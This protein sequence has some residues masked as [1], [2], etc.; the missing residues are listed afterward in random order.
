MSQ[1][2][3]TR[4]IKRLSI[5]V[6]SILVVLAALPL[7]VKFGAIYGL[8]K[9]GATEVVIDDVDLNLF[10]GVLA[11]KGLQVGGGENP[12]LQLSYLQI[13]V[14]YLPLFEKRFLLEA[15]Q[16]E[17]VRLNIREQQDR[18][19][20]VV[21]IPISNPEEDDMPSADGATPWGVG[22]RKVVLRDVELN[23]DVKNVV[24]NV[25]VTKFDVSELYSW[26]P[27]DVSA[28]L[29]EGEINGAPL[30]ISGNVQPFAEIPEYKSH[31][32]IDALSLSPL[33]PFLNGY[34][35]SYDVSVSLDTDL[36][37]LMTKDGSVE[38]S[39]EGT[40]DVEIGSIVRKD[41]ELKDS[42]IGW[43]GEVRLELPVDADLLVKT[44]GKL[45]SRALNSEFPGFQMGIKHQGVTWQGAVSID[46]KDVKDVENSIQATGALALLE[47]VVI[48]NKELIN[49]VALQRFSVDEV[50]V[51]GLNDIGLGRINLQKLAVL[52]SER[53]SSKSPPIEP[54]SFR[55]SSV[56]SL[57]DIAI[58][59]VQLKQKNDIAIDS[60]V[61]NGLA[62]NITVLESGEL[63][64]ISAYV[65]ALTSR[66]DSGSEKIE[67][68][69]KGASSEVQ[70][71]EQESKP[72]DLE[73]RV[74]DSETTEKEPAFQFALKE[75][76][77]DG[78]NN[79]QFSDHSVTPHYS[80]KFHID[81]VIIGPLD[82]KQV[83]EL[84][85]VDVA[86]RRGEFST[87]VLNGA[88][89]PLQENVRG[90]LEFVVKGAELTNVSSYV[91]KATG[92]A[93]GSGQFNL[94][95][96]VTL[97]NG[98]MQ[99]SNEVLLKQLVLTPVND[100]LVASV[101]KQFSM[102]IGISLGL[103]KDS[104]GNIELSVPLEGDL[105]DPSV[106]IEYVVRLAL[107]QAIKKGSLSYLKYAIQPYGAIL[108]VGEAVG[109]MVMEVKVAPFRFVA[110]S[111]DIVDEDLQ[112]VPKLAVLL[113]SL[114]D[115]SFT[116][117]P[118]VTVEDDPAQKAE[119]EMNDDL[120]ALAVS[121]L[122]KIK[123]QLV[124]DHEIAP[125][126]ILFCRA[127]VGEGTP[128]V[129]LEF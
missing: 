114:P 128:R 36:R 77:F 99:V 83:S 2:E 67:D 81:K 23:V 52:S 4:T 10:A 94:D 129:E 58:E 32:K 127:K 102:P 80:E 103:L 64:I 91:E 122:A 45:I 28:L 117:C 50:S 53:S 34:I 70:K 74:V 3:R 101:S 40:F 29:L 123:T 60:I 107:V 21:P 14:A 87:V 42:H 11:I 33:A 78:E 35:E 15:V 38:L 116:M 118:I 57:S 18:L 61:L 88:L 105:N 41:V 43:E 25:Q 71:N 30:S 111:S 47:L 65:E 124:S 108:L 54:P 13:E 26:A 76:R 95:T 97:A 39:Q 121:R 119:M 46:V 98:Q 19:Y 66:L 113:K 6:I 109:D 8:K 110:G 51:A 72:L 79:I 17:K 73:A 112:Y 68:V 120:K 115:K 93:I 37:I 1:P 100:E 55:S 56:L 59:K 31:L 106:N 104:D 75:F 16:L 82:S 62:A 86:L 27:G 126:R 96:S 7:V 9:A 85:S 125:E 63:D 24:S 12:D 49:P 92:Y 48:D 69:A 90:E 5:A 44:D 89:A 20:I 22:L 84:T